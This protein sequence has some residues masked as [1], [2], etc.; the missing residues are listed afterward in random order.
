[1]VVKVVGRYQ[2]QARIGQGAMANVY[3]AYDPSINRVLAI[4]VLKREY[5][6]NPEFTMRFLREAR[7]AGALSHPNIVTI[8]DVGEIEGFPYIAMELLDGE[9]LDKVAQ[10]QGQF[11]STDILTVG[12]QLADALRYAHGQGVVH[13]DIKPSNIMLGKDGRSVKILD[14]G[15]ARLADAEGAAEQLSMTQVGQVL[16]TPRYMSPEQALGRPLDGRSDLFSV[17]ALLYELIMGKPAFTGASAATLALQIT[18]LDPPPI[19]VDCPR[20]LKFIVNK[21]LAKRS[22]QRFV[23]GAALH[24]ALQRERAALEAAQ[25]ADRRRL[26]FPI[27]AALVVSAVTALALLIGIGAVLDTQY[28]AMERVAVTSGSSIVSF[29]AANAALPA[30]ENAMLPADQRDWLPVQAFISTASADPNVSQ[31]IVAD[32]DGVIRAASDPRLVGAH[33]MEPQGRRVTRDASGI[34]VTSVRAADGTRSFRFAHNI[35]Y[36]GQRVG[37]VDISVRKT[38]LQAAAMLT[39]LSLIGLGLM[40]LALV[41]VLSVLAARYVMQP[42][43]ALRTGL[44]D[45]ADGNLDFR[46]SQRRSDEFGD[47]FDGFNALMDTV[48]A[49]AAPAAAAPALN[50]DATMIAPPSND[51]A[52]AKGVAA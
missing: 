17:G 10:R 23:S 8:Y 4:K 42:V 37:L 28:R 25:G 6:R 22:E 47:L 34:A 15:I 1:M 29:V 39:R 20:G 32:H 3:R 24:M 27:R 2:I 36:A 43:R 5:C 44:Q 18:Q 7:A 16:G 11:A 12:C 33:Y 14:F 45:A 31:M 19:D 40:I 49:R 48:A 13:R 9:P 52:P 41:A 35:E 30:A 50:L 21:L 51:I 46:M 38:E 26:A